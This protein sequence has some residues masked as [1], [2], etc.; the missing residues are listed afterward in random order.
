VLVLTYRDQEVTRDH[1]LRQLLGVTPSARRLR[2]TCLSADAVRQLGVGAG[3][4]TDRV[5]QVTSGN[6]LFVN[7]VLRSDDLGHVPPTIVETV[8]ARLS[9]L[10]A[11]SRDAVERL[12]VIPSAVERWLVEAVVPGGL[13]GLAAA[14]ERGVLSVSPARIVFRHELMRRAVVGSMP[15]VRRVTCNEAVLATLLNS[16]QAVD[17]SRIVHHAVEAGDEAAIVRYGPAAAAEA[18]AAESHREA[19]S[20]YRLVL[21]HRSAFSLT[22]QANL[23]EGYAIECYTVGMAELAVQAQEDAVS[24]RRGFSD[25]LALGTSLRWLS[26]MYWWAG[27]RANAERAAAEAIEVLEDAGDA[28]A[29]AFALSNQSQLYALA[30]H[31]EE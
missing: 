25:A 16:P 17:V 10:D 19:V 18:V 4:D 13:S 3:M 15:A 24:V 1:P 5:F 20:H 7:E 12:A 23:L 21:R 22:E 29:L 2:L 14:E 9:D 30:G 26:R 11:A 27:S 31:R 28:H 6:P 8:Q